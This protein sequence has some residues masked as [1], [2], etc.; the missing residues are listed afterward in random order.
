VSL[1]KAMKPQLS[2]NRVKVVKN[3]HSSKRM[4]NF[5]N[6]KFNF[7]FGII[8]VNYAVEIDYNVMKGTEFLCRYKRVFL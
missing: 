2:D 7:L 6:K 1:T 5:C 3:L 4:Q 8:T